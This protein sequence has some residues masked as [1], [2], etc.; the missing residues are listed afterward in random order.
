MLSSI[1]PICVLS[2]IYPALLYWLFFR[3]YLHTNIRLS[4]H[5]HAFIHYCIGCF[6]VGHKCVKVETRQIHHVL[7]M[8]SLP[9]SQ[10]KTNQKSNK[11]FPWHINYSYPFAWQRCP[12]VP[13]CSLCS[14][15]MNACNVGIREEVLFSLR[16]GQR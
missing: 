13:G 7:N 1:N 3:V 15:L 11:D 8:F 6:A 12:W 14:M 16:K 5:K 2:Y 10:N 9:K 4:P